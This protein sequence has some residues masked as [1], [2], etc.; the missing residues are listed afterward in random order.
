MDGLIQLLLNVQPATL[1]ILAVAGVALE[2]RIRR[3]EDRALSMEGKLDLLLEGHIMRG[4]NCGKTS[5]P[6]SDPGATGD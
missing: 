4:D 6:R 3:L 1:A 5:E 2:R